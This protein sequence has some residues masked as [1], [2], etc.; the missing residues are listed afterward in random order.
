MQVSKDQSSRLG[1]V[2]SK[3]SCGYNVDGP[4]Y[5]KHH[6]GVALFAWENE[7]G[8]WSCS[9]TGVMTCGGSTLE[10]CQIAGEKAADD[11]DSRDR[12]RFIG[13]EAFAVLIGDET[14]IGFYELKED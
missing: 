10:E 12:D 5:A 2:E 3:G 8:F 7:N 9:V 4:V 6:R 13:R 14:T 1:W 11:S